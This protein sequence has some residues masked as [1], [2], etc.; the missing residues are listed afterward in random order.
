MFDEEEFEEFFQSDNEKTIKNKSFDRNENN[1][2]KYFENTEKI[3]Q[4]PKYIRNFL[5]NDIIVGRKF[6]DIEDKVKYIEI[7]KNDKF[8]LLGISPNITFLHLYEPNESKE[9]NENKF[10]GFRYYDGEPKQQISKY[11]TLINCYDSKYYILEKNQTMKDINNKLFFD[12]D[13]DCFSIINNSIIQKYRNKNNSVYGETFPELIGYCY[14]LKTLNKALNK[15]LIF[16][17]PLIPQIFKPDTLEEDI[18]DNIEDNMTYIEPLIYNGHIS[19]IIFAGKKNKRINIILDMSRY[20]TSTSKLSNIIFPKSIIDKYSIYPENPIQNYSSCCLW[21]YGEIECILKNDKY[22][23]LKSIYNYIKPGS[24]QFFIDVINIIGKNYYGIDN[25]FKEEKERSKDI[26]LINLNRLFVNGKINYSIDKNIMFTQFLN[27][28][29]LLCDSFFY[30]SQDYK[31]LTITQKSLEK[32]INYK[33]LLEINFKFY[34]LLEREN[35]MKIVLEAILSE[36]NYIKKILKDIEDNFNV[37]FIKKNIFSYEIFL[38]KDIMEGKPIIFP[39]SD[40]MQKKIQEINFNELLKDYFLDL[41]K[42]KKNLERKYKLYSEED[43]VKNLNLS[44]SICFQIM[45]K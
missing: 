15:N 26:N 21:F 28:N 3:S 2:D 39:I 12:N 1:Y 19:L 33:N 38:F 5:I 14:G 31:V 10:I 6:Y 36:I 44:N 41:E 37:D 9:Y 32:F 22:A 42:R 24:I 40:E 27:L 43:V 8:D 29:N 25:L 7:F 11:F 16:I 30:I 34:K 45:N 23:S 17:E 4:S 35:D 13:L 18:L 20:H